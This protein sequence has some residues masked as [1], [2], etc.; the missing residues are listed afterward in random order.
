[1]STPLIWILFPLLASVGFLFMMRRH[2]ILK[3][4]GTGFSLSM[5]FLAAVLPINQEFNFLFWELRIGEE[6]LVFGRRFVLSDASRPVIIL[7]FLICTF[8][9]FILDPEII[10]IQVIPLGLAGIVLILTAYAVDPIYYGALFFAFLA[11]IYVVLLSPPGGKPTQGAL[12]FLVFQILGM[13]FILFA[14]WLASWIDLTTGDELLL[15]RSLMILSLGFSFLLAIF[16]FTS[17]IPMIAEKN[18]PFLAGFVLNTYFLGVFL[19]GTRF[20][21]QAGWFVQ[22]INIQGPLQTAGAIMLGVGGILAIFTKNLSRLMGAV[23]ITEIGKSLLAISLFLAGFPL[24]FGMV[25]IQSLALGVWVISLSHLGP[26]LKDFE[27]E[28]AVGAA[29]QWPGV[30]SGFLVGYFTLAGSPFLAG[31]PLYWALGIGLNIYPY[32]IKTWY[33]LGTVGLLIGGIRAVGALTLDSGEETVLQLGTPYQRYLIYVLNGIL[34]IIGLFPQGLLNLTQNITE[35][36][37]GG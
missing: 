17:W 31:F 34:L 6:F 1:M 5:A 30:T 3:W 4:V 25:I 20:I 7:L 15:Y 32:W 27:Y 33:V 37:L 8:W 23:M 11:L 36:I 16:P 10:P 9:F 24:Y 14:A 12:R 35:L 29:R 21:T 18:L 26:V 13:L 28:S 22:G 19:F 2:Q